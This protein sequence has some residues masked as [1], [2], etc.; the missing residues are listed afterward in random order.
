MIVILK[1]YDIK[2]KRDKLTTDQ[3]SCEI[4]L[5]LRI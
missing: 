1:Q 4:D 3:D 5:Y 2:T